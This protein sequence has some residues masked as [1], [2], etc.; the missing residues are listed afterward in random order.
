MAYGC[1][2]YEL[3]L[4]L[5][6]NSPPPSFVF[7]LVLLSFQT[8][9]LKL[10]VCPSSSSYPPL[11]P[12]YILLFLNTHTP[13]SLSPAYSH[14]HISTQWLI[15]ILLLTTVIASNLLT[16]DILIPFLL[17]NNNSNI[18]RW[19]TAR[20]LFPLRVILALAMAV[21]RSSTSRLLLSNPRTLNLF[22]SQKASLKQLS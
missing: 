11:H 10:V 14:H 18:L 6:P 19:L 12:L 4:R 8:Y 2:T 22:K 3:R 9:K 5:C 1:T 21:P 15:Y 17:L 16:I 13:S 20:S 7:Y